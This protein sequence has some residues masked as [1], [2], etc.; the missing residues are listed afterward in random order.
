[1][2]GIAT[3]KI[4]QSTNKNSITINIKHFNECLKALRKIKTEIAEPFNDSGLIFPNSDEI[5]LDA[6]KNELIHGG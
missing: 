1:M 2:D 6:I 5:D 3:I 4:N